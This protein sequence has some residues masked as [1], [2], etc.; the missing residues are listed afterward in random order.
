MN[1]TRTVRMRSIVSVGSAFALLLVVAECVFAE[2]PFFQDKTITII[3]GRRP[4]GLGDVRTR[5]VMNLLSEHI[6]GK[7]TIVTQYLP[8]AGGRKAA[9]RLY[10]SVKPD[11]LTLANIGA[12]FVSNAVLGQPGV[13][14]DVDKFVFLGSGNS[15]QSYVF[16]TRKG[17]GLDSLEK[18][19]AASGVRVGGQSV[20][21]DIY[22]IG[23]L[24]AWLMDLKDPRFVTGYSGP[25][26][27]L[28]MMRGE[29]D[30]R[31]NNSAT[32]LKRSPE[33]IEKDL[34]DFHSIVEIPQGYRYSHPAYEK[35]PSMQ[36]FTKT[37]TERNVLSM[38]RNFRWLGS[39]F[40][41]PPG[42]PEERVKIL[43]Q[44]FTDLYKD[45]RFLKVWEQYTG[46]PASPLTPDQQAK[47]FKEIPRDP[48]A[49]RVFKQIGGPGPLPAR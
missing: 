12:G 15:I 49:V 17:A 10:R 6:P 36:S 26:I 30:A 20:G 34:V 47:A 2:K 28:A 19:Q 1:F 44:A 9:N 13:N 29:V 35:L 38:Y 23:R 3:Q 43:K 37:D 33:W 7:P 4:G 27:D 48:E 39:P 8:G 18:L 5:A 32:V 31:T 42:V 11:G 45:P 14:Y 41:L 25:E 21:H 40:I 16:V 46:E 22:T 24:F